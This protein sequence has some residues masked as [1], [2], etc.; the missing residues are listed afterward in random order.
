MK[1]I[2]TN[3][4]SRRSTI[5]LAV[6][7]ENYQRRE[8]TITGFKPYFYIPDKSGKYKSVFGDHLKKVVLHNPGSVPRVR[9]SMIKKGH[10]YDGCKNWAHHEAD[11]PY[12]RRFLIDTGIKSGIEFP[13][14]EKMSYKEIKSAEVDIE[15]R[16]WFMDI[17][18]MDG[19]GFPDPEEVPRP[20]TATTIFDSYTGQY[21]TL[22]LKENSDNK[23]IDYGFT[24]AYIFND[25]MEYS[26]FFL[27]MYNK[28]QPDIIAGYNVNFDVDYTFNRLKRIGLDVNFNGDRFDFLKAYEVVFQTY[29]LKLKNLAI[30]EGYITP[31]QYI[32]ASKLGDI[33]RND[34]DKF[35]WY[36]WQDV[37]LLQRLDKDKKLID[38]F[39][40]MKQF[41]GI[42]EIPSLYYLT[43]RI[44]K[45]A[46]DICK[47]RGVVAPS[48]GVRSVQPIKGAEPKEPPLGVFSNIASF[49][50][51]AYY[52]TII[53]T[54]GLSPENKIDPDPDKVIFRKD[55][56]GILVEVIDYVLQERYRIEGIMKNYDPGSD[57]YEI[58]EKKRYIAKIL[59]TALWGYVSYAKSRFCDYHVPN[60]VTGKAREGINLLEKIAEKKGYNV[61]YKHTDSVYVNCP[62]DD[63]QKL[64]NEFNKELKRY[65]MLKY[66]I[67]EK[68]YRIHLKY[69]TYNKK[70]MFL[71]VKNRYASRITW[72][73]GQECDFVELKGLEAIKSNQSKFTK[74]K[75]RELIHKMLNENISHD[76]VMQWLKDTFKKFQQ[77]DIQ[78]IALVQ[79]IRKPFNEYV[80]KPPVVRGAEFTNEYLNAEI[81]SGYT[82]YYLYVKSVK[83][84]PSTDVI[85]FD[86][87]RILEIDGI[88]IYEVDW[89]KM[90]NLEIIQKVNTIMKA[91]GIDTDRLTFDVVDDE[92]KIS[93]STSILDW[94]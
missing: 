93:R 40:P 72:K 28:Y 65:F 5:Y 57:E 45:I 82:V 13:D 48:G 15:P 68:D 14:K 34:F 31:D 84:L 19:V 61:I 33:Y 49:D 51:T 36:N 35:I 21:F 50:F 9:E 29:G 88:K 4:W 1:G 37:Y 24:K 6:R 81:E 73:K 83:D 38:F 20:I 76:N 54:F 60:L 16:I 63:A 55:R 91:Y 22:G 59:S 85:S 94:G 89:M 47:K 67:K 32:L 78:D 46:L 42:E 74:E 66:N 69:E 43:P 23:I 3:M 80:S 25:E 41:L 64:N 26:I 71:G 39:W 62:E 10:P 86:D 79:N 7:D 12:T 56:K 53:L 92:L 11:I 77:Q 8:L 52:P 17:E 27:K 87:S 44:D 90:F 58:L 30:H 2:I 18:V 70:I 75:Q